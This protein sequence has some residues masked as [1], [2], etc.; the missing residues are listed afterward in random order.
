VQRK[1]RCKYRDLRC[2]WL[3]LRYKYHEAVL[4]CFSVLC[5]P[6]MYPK[7]PTVDRNPSNYHTKLLI[8]VHVWTVLCTKNH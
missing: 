5:L 7:M 4:P 1:L 2:E 8:L 6:E 3:S